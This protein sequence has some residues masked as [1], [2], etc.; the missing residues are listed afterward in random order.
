MNE[1]DLHEENVDDKMMDS[2][3]PEYTP[4]SPLRESGSES[5]KDQSSSEGEKESAND[6]N[7]VDNANFVDSDKV[8]VTDKESEEFIA[9][10]DESEKPNTCSIDDKE[11]VKGSNSDSVKDENI[12]EHEKESGSDENDVDNANDADSDQ[13]EITDKE[14][15]AVT[16]DCDVRQKAELG[17]IDDK[18]GVKGSDSKGVVNNERMTIEVQD[19]SDVVEVLS[20]TVDSKVVGE[21]TSVEQDSDSG[22]RSDTSAE[23]SDSEEVSHSR[24]LTDSEKEDAAQT[25]RKKKLMKVRVKIEPPDSSYK[26]V[27]VQIKNEDDQSNS[28][29]SMLTSYGDTKEEDDVKN[30]EWY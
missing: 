14:N 21:I 19:K 6:E 12:S 26:M 22:N 1:G 27:N 29:R 16:M 9:D 3:V 7:D 4:L 18:K 24:T 28:M 30:T 10:C 17:T 8:E 2:S 5:G 23:L 13:V 11:G 25:E 20:E 15:K